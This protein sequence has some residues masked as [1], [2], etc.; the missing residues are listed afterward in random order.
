MANAGKHTQKGKMNTFHSRK[1]TRQNARHGGS[2]NRGSQFR[3]LQSKVHL[4]PDWGL[5]A[6]PCS[7]AAQQA[8]SIALPRFQ[9][10]SGL[11]GARPRQAVYTRERFST[12]HWFSGAVY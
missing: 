12:A 3:T 8:E 6:G 9:A 2:V 5:I 1:T 11:K 10:R 7:L 4:S